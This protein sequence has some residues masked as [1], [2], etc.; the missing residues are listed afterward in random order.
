MQIA[1]STRN[2]VC[3]TGVRPSCLEPVVEL[4]SSKYSV[5]EL[6]RGAI[7]WVLQLQTL[8]DN[9]VDAISTSSNQKQAKQMGK[10]KACI[11]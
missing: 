2:E 11:V 9:M 5:C 3:L 4:C 6:N 10:K 8:Q 7:T 1:S